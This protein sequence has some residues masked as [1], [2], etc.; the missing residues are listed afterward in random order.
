MFTGALFG[1]ARKE[2]I[3][4]T[5]KGNKVVFDVEGISGGWEP[6]KHIYTGTIESP[7]RMSGTIE[8]PRGT[9]KW[10]AIKK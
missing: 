7:T 2:R 8:T 3:I 6:F 9:Y 4:G 5:V 10:T 1:G